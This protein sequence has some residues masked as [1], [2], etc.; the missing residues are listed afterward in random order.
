MLAELPLLMKLAFVDCLFF[1]RVSLMS[2]RNLELDS[3]L[4]RMLSLSVLFA[5][6]FCSGGVFGDGASLRA[7]A[8]V[9][10]VDYCLFFSSSSSSANCKVSLDIS[11]SFR[12]RGE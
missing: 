10:R 7:A 3:M 6:G 12:C 8:I 9:A 2:N 4:L 5:R 11:E 1:T